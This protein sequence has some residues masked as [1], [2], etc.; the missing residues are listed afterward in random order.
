M[1]TQEQI[2]HCSTTLYHR[3]RFTTVRL[4]RT[5]ACSLS[6]VHYWLSH[7][8]RQLR[9]APSRTDAEQ[10]RH[11][12]T[13]VRALALQTDPTGEPLYPSARLIA[14]ALYQYHRVS[15]SRDTVRRDLDATG[16]VARVR[17]RTTALLNDSAKRL[18]ST[19]GD[20]A[21]YGGNVDVATA[22]RNVD[23]RTVAFSDEK[24]FDTNHHGHR[25]AW[26]PAGTS[27]K[28]RLVS[29]WPNRVHVWGCVGDNFRML[30]LF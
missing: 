29:R 17:P 2:T 30:L 26:I 14:A 18:A 22:H 16:F 25:Q 24:I 27:P 1:L 11:R 19:L 20:V 3:E 21:N 13:L 28:G 23:P 6:T 9:R 7:A 10:L 8:Q 12:R 4:A 5:F 15:A